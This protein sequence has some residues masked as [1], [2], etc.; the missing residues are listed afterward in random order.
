MMTTAEERIKILKKVADGELTAAEA[1]EMLAVEPA[2]QIEV[3]LEAPAALKNEAATAEAMAPAI[4]VEEI[5]AGKA[6]GSP[7]QQA[8]KKPTWL[9]VRVDDLSTGKRKVTVNIPLRLMKL[10]M[11]FGSAFAPELAE[12]DLEEMDTALAEQDKGV[13]VDVVDE[14]DGHHVQVYVD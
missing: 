4:E 14:E 9:H 8:G 3:D 5:P 1:A 2:G 7:T 6:D 10:C 13:L 12:I 11:R